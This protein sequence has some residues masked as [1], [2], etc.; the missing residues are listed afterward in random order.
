MAELVHNLLTIHDDDLDLIELVDQLGNAYMDD[1]DEEG[2]RFVH[3]SSPALTLFDK[4]SVFEMERRCSHPFLLLSDVYGETRGP[5][6]EYVC[7]RDQ[8]EPWPDFLEADTAGEMVRK[9][10]TLRVSP[11][12]SHRRQRI[13]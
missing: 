4:S 13:A 7:H 5:F 3:F 6:G 11:R 2:Y 8:D 10:S 12:G 1:P 9:A